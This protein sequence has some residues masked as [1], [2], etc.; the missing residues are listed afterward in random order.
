MCPGIIAGDQCNAWS[1]FCILHTTSPLSRFNTS[2]IL[3]SVY[4]GWGVNSTNL[5]LLPNGTFTD[6][7]PG[8]PLPP[9][10]RWPPPSNQ[11]PAGPGGSGATSSGSS[12][13][14]QIIVGVVVGV[15]GA[16][17]LV[18]AASAFWYLR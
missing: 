3:L 6:D 8:L 12:T 17:L 10:G 14:W 15:G 7:Q 13:Q 16:L 2:A 11:P 4:A 5:L 18:A 9:P 1:H